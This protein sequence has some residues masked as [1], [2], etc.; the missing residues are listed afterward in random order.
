MTELPRGQHFDPAGIF[1]H[2]DAMRSRE[3]AAIGI[4][5]VDGDDVF[6]RKVGDLF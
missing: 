3:H 1:R 2:R 6:R 4:D 5:G